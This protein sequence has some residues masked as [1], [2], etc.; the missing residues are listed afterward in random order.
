MNL[1]EELKKIDK[2]TLILWGRQREIILNL[3]DSYL[4]DR[5][6]KNRLYDE[7]RKWNDLARERSSILMSIRLVSELEIED[8]RE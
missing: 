4:Y 6:Q 3:M 8:E 7:I 5:D 2:D 1:T